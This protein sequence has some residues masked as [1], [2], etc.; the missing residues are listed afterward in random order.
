MMRLVI[1]AVLANFA[2]L[3][4][5]I[6]VDGVVTWRERDR[7]IESHAAEQDLGAEP[8]AAAKTWATWAHER[9][10]RLVLT[11]DGRVLLV[12]SRTYVSCTR[13]TR[14]GQPGGWRSWVGP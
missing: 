7:A 11:D 10:Y 1:I 8:I 13:P 4:A 14:P 5:Q 6:P 2:S 12:L 3:D 9:D